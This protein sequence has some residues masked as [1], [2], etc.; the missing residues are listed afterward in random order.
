MPPVEV[1]FEEVLKDPPK[2]KSISSGQITVLLRELK[3][4]LESR[5]TL[6]R[7]TD[8][9]PAIFVG[10]THGDL[11]TTSSIATRHFL[12]DEDAI[13]IFLGDYV[14]RG[15]QDVHTFNFV[16]I[17]KLLHPDRVVLLRG[18]HENEEINQIYG[19]LRSAEMDP[20]VG[21]EGFKHYQE[22][23]AQMPLAVFLEWNRVFG[24]HGGIP[25][26]PHHD[27][28]F[29]LEELKSLKKRR[30]FEDMDEVSRQ[31]LW[32][33]PREGLAEGYEYNIARGMAWL[34]DRPVFDAFVER[35]DIRLVVKS[36]QMFEDGHR[37]FFDDRLLSIFSSRHYSGQ[38]I[39]PRIA[40]VEVDGSVQVLEV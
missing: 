38:D 3:A 14:D 13:L 25:F 31:M 33:D 10:D 19:F 32:G 28:P 4:L 40:R 26:D 39:E 18:N 15:L 5:G 21:K 8:P 20:R 30:F 27:G 16:A 37:Y 17:L 7:L 35:N 23:F 12:P 6:I 9:R 1:A 11:H 22:V 24:V 36:H 2:V 29:A 34:Y